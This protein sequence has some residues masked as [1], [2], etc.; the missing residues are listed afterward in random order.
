MTVDRKPGAARADGVR[1]G[2]ALLHDP[3]RNK[4]TGFTERERDELGLRGLLPP[5]VLTQAEQ[6]GRFLSNMRALPTDLDKYVRRC[7]AGAG[8]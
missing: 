7:R 3:L 6:A 1:R 2:V 8:R 5:A 4:G